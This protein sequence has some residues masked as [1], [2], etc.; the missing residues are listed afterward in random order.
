V[1]GHVGTVAEIPPWFQDA[2]EKHCPDSQYR[3]ERMG[4]NSRPS[5]L[6]HLNIHRLTSRP[7]T[8]LAGPS[9]AVDTENELAI[10]RF[11]DVD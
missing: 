5:G 2:I 3:V 10:S 1:T 8:E 4:G 11:H 6:R 7:E 9:G